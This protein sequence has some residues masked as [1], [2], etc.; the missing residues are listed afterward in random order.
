MK[1]LFLLH[2]RNYDKN[3]DI[4]TLLRMLAYIV[5]LERVIWDFNLQNIAY[6]LPYLQ[7]ISFLNFIHFISL[8]L[9]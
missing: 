4:T 7:R 5:L 8:N 3:I 1:R 9:S 2:L 6:F